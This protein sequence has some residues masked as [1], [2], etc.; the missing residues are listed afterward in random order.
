MRGTFGPLVMVVQDRKRTIINM[1]RSV[2]DFFFVPM[3]TSRIRRMSSRKI[4][5]LHIFINLI[6]I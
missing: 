2:S 6:K 5:I 1:Q 4:I 3:S